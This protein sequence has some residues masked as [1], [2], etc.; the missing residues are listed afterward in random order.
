[1]PAAPTVNAAIVSGMRLPM[2]AISL[3]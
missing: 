1:M 2:P 3:M